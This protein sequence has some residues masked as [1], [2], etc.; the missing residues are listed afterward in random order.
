MSALPSK[1]DSD[2][3]DG[4]QVLPVVLPLLFGESFPVMPKSFPV[5]FHREFRQKPR[6]CWN[7]SCSR[8][9]LGL[10][11][12]IF[13][14]FFPVSREFGAETGPIQTAASASILTLCPAI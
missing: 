7:S 3:V 10:D 8:R 11:L 9:R 5:N 1:A 6:R 14:V 4:R 2:W 13:P 12:P